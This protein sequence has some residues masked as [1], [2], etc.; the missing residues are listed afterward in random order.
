MTKILF[1]MY[2]ASRS[3]LGYGTK[4]NLFFLFRK[5]QKI[6]KSDPN[7]KILNIWKAYLTLEIVKQDKCPKYNRSSILLCAT[8][9]CV[10]LFTMS[11]KVLC[12]TCF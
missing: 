9:Y 7:F 10:L 4:S 8:H 3:I 5:L 11:S 6:S 12:H 1:V 2:F